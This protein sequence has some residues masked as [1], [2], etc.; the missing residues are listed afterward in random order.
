MCG[1]VLRRKEVRIMKNRDSLGRWIAALSRHGRAY[2]ENEMKPYGIGKGQFPYLI[3]LLLFDGCSQD[4]LSEYLLID[5]T[6]TARAL[7][8]LEK[9]GF[10]RR[11]VDAQDNRIKRVYVTEKTRQLEDVIFEAPQNWN[12]ILVRGFSNEERAQALDLLERMVENVG[13]EMMDK[14]LTGKKR[15]RTD[16]AARAAHDLNAEGVHSE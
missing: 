10:V 16:G 12:R 9:Q 2:M 6:L 4:E 14:N 3:R 7:A 13:Y 5:K 15:I 11:Q 1:T 8:K